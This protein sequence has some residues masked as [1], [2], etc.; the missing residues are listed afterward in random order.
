MK[1]GVMVSGILFIIVLFVL[2]GCSS[3]ITGQLVE[4]N[5][6]VVYREPD[7]ITTGG[8]TTQSAGSVSY[9]CG[10]NAGPN[11]IVYDSSG[12]QGQVSDPS[13]CTG[14]CW[15][16]TAGVASGP[17]S[18]YWGPGGDGEKPPPYLIDCSIIGGPQPPCSCP[19][20]YDYH[21]Q[22]WDVGGRY[23][24]ASAWADCHTGDTCPDVVAC[25]GHSCTYECTFKYYYG[26]AFDG[27]PKPFLPITSLGPWGN[28]N[29]WH[30]SQ[31]CAH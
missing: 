11:E 7:Y 28:G 20:T 25:E 18:P 1:K 13:A 8:G 19:P 6:K 15:V 30:E 16:G 5:R 3:E 31:Q 27:K 2:S 23:G 24:G 4:S 17:V 10:C 22:S 29:T 14:H 21:I 12:C 26:P 9:Y